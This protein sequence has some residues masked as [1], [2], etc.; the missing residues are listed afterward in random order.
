VRRHPL[1]QM[2]TIG[3]VASAIGVAISLSIDWFPPQ[4]DTASKKIDHLYDV[5]LVFSVPIF[6]LVMTVAIYS[7]WRFRAKPGDQADG[8]PIHGN[9]RLE[10]VWVAVP[11]LIVSSLAVYSWVELNDIEAKKPN[12]LPVTVTAQQFTWSFQ[13]PQAGGKSVNSSELVLPVDRHVKFTIKAKD[14]I[15]SF[16]VP[17]FR[18]KQD[19]V[20]GTSQHVR[21]TPTKEGSYEVVCAELCGLGHSTMRNPVRVVSKAEFT[22]WLAKRAGG[23][24]A[25]GAKPGTAGQ[26]DAGKQVFTDTGGCGACHTLADAGTSGTV[27]PNLDGLA[28][29][30]KKFGKGKSLDEYVKESILDP[31]AVVVKGFPAGTMPKNFKDQL[32][33]QEIDALVQYLVKSSKGA[34][35]Q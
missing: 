24:A 11:F 7:V 4:A 25:A 22:S 18:L 2:L 10:V 32:S 26:A 23:G 8:A 27:G 28:A 31:D 1:A 6:V 20:P 14:V 33:P 34:S 29:D 19:A 30:A 3:V 12:E 9:T 13:Y 16:W 17:A 35:S 21:L 5:L 15:H